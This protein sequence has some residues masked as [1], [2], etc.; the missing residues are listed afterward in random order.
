MGRIVLRARGVGL[1]LTLAVC[2]F[3]ASAS[4]LVEPLPASNYRTELVCTIMLEGIPDCLAEGLVPETPAASAR[5]TPIGMVLPAAPAHS[6][7]AEGVYGLRPE[8]L[9]AVYELPLNA[10]DDQTIAIIEPMVDPTIESDLRVYDEEFDLPP[11]TEANGCFRQVNQDG[12]P[13]SP[14]FA[15]AEWSANTSLNVEIAHAICQNCHILLVGTESNLFQDL[16]AG[17]QTAVAEGAT[18][19]VNPYGAVTSRETDA[20][21]QPGIVITAATGDRGY[22]NWEGGYSGANYPASSPFVVAVG[23][24][25]LKPFL[26]SWAG[27]EAWSHT[28]SGC[29]TQIGVA[30]P[31]QTHLPNWSGS[32]CQTERAV[33]DI[34]ADADPL[35]GVAIYDSTPLAPWFPG[36]ATF[37]GTSLSASIV[38]AAFALA[39]GSHTTSSPA[40]AI[41]ARRGE[42][43]LHDIFDGSNYPDSSCLERPFCSAQSGW[44]GPTGVGTL[45]GVGA[46]EPLGEPTVTGLSPPGGRAMGRQWV[47][48]TG[49]GFAGATAVRFG[50][51]QTPII[52]REE[53]AITV[54]TQ[55]HFPES[56]D[57]TVTGADGTVSE[58]SPADQ[59]EY[60][61][62][63]PVVEQVSPPSGPP[64]GG[65][66]VTF[67]GTGLAEISTVEFGVGYY[68]EPTWVQ[69][70]EVIVVTPRHPEMSIEPRL[71]GRYAQTR[72][73][74]TYTAPQY[75]KLAIH[76]AGSGQGTVTVAP[77][78]GACSSDCVQGFEDGT[79]LTLGATPRAGSTFAGWSGE[80]C[81][82]TTFC[83]FTI[84][85]NT[86]VTA[87][88]EGSPSTGSQTTKKTAA[89]NEAL[90]LHEAKV[91]ALKGCLA[92]AHKAYHH[93]VRLA[94]AADH[95]RA[96]ALRRAKRTEYRAVVSC[97][98]RY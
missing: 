80:G 90:H 54:E 95:G 98:R 33:A 28:G 14:E 24:T 11:C 67:K 45:R 15:D 63:T 31:W 17:V 65:T 12:E 35:S 47:E 6:T 96:A 81:S 21:D 22:D 39:G 27:E 73:P 19:I 51:T 36:W 57:V 68:A 76:T 56:V 59:Y 89:T 23:G 13:S 61:A 48:I 97:R 4:A 40:S 43:T 30:Q 3:P 16:E 29:G 74:F 82:G 78:G 84:R 52:K 41:Y 38:N 32:R 5:T 58:I 87:T 55:E 46:L 10:P 93:A 1:L 20:Y 37:G 66:E 62:L 26:T 91:R 85:G 44:D 42:S 77:S 72:A 8:D 64:A 34:A 60:F 79:P 92:A 71:F 88:F 2:V 49:S 86:E 18:E 75:D 53:H 69:E 50:E 9:H 94:R 7:A 70:E 25:T 83:R